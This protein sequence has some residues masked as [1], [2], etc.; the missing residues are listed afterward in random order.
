MM[1][2][3][4]HVDPV[5]EILRSAPTS[6]R[7]RAVAWDAVYQSKDESDLEQRLRILPLPD[8]TKA[9]LWEFRAKQQSSSSGKPAELHPYAQLGN[10]V[11]AFGKRALQL[12]V[13]AVKA[14]DSLGRA[15]IPEVVGNAL[16][17]E[18]GTTGPINALT[19]AGQASI[20]AAGRAGE[21]FEQGNVIEGVRRSVGAVPFVGPPMDAAAD[22]MLEGK[23]GEGLGDAFNFGMLTFGPAAAANA[24]VNMPA[25]VKPRLN[26]AEQAAV[27]FGEQ[28]GIPI[29][30]GTATGSQWVRNVQKRVASQ[31]GGANRAEAFRSQHVQALEREAQLL[32]EQANQTRTGRP[33]APENSISAGEAVTGRLEGRINAQARVADSAYSELRAL[34][35]Q[36]AQRI[37]GNLGQATAAPPTSQMAFTNQPLAVDVAAAKASLKPLYENLLREKELVGALQGGK[38]RTL[39]ALDALMKGP[40]LA[41]LSVVDGALGDIKAMARTADL[42]ALR[43]QG[44][45]TA[46]QAVKALEAQVTA[47]AR[48]AGPDVFNAL[49]R[50]RQ[51][52]IGKYETAAVRDTLNIAEPVQ[53]FRQLTQ[54]KDVSLERLRAVAREAPREVPKVARAYLEGLIDEATREG[55]FAHA[56]KLWAEWSKLGPE[57]K[58]ILFRGDRALIRDLDNFFLLAKKVAE[59]PN[60]SGTAPV[61]TAV[62]VGGVPV[63]NVLA[64]LLYTRKGVRALTQGFQVA[65]GPRGRT[66]ARGVSLGELTKVARQVMA[67]PSPAMADEDGTSPEPPLDRRLL[68]GR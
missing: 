5:E 49:Q 3:Q 68:K 18:P 46:A 8:A 4:T 21:A 45:A 35:Q 7:V 16:G 6:D 11:L 44:Q 29:D 14:V 58:A 30:A 56:D 24:R 42:P 61:L 62:N 26:A 1:Q 65:L 12:P 67:E 19:A 36:A 27:Q 40:D 32:A 23:Y 25:A 2:D 50:G 52:T 9:A 28:R 38:A 54:S 63:A 15:L 31:P 20:D 55:G 51:A 47:T 37:Q 41:P 43:T 59:N 17:F 10:E 66:A 39:V 22:K 53:V 33:G 64:R 34:E 48:A 60:P 57:T 13:E